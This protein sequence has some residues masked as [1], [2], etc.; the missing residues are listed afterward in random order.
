MNADKTPA[1][2]PSFAAPGFRVLENAT[3]VIL[4]VA[5]LAVAWLVLVAYQPERAR[6][7][8]PE[9]EV[10]IVLAILLAALTLVSLVALLHTKKR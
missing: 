7:A 9:V 1:A 3:A 6:L 2:E 5:V 4:V 10:G 8:S